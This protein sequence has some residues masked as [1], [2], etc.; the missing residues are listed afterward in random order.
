MNAN[1]F[2]NFYRRDRQYVILDVGIEEDL[3]DEYLALQGNQG[4]L[5]DLNH[6]YFNRVIQ[7]DFYKIV[8]LEKDRIL[9]SSATEEAMAMYGNLLKKNREV[10]KPFFYFHYHLKTLFLREI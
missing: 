5:N 2:K 3:K 8:S 10:V 1:L 9:A 7:Q 4:Y 6:L